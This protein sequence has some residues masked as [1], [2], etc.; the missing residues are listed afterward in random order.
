MAPPEL[1]LVAD[2]RVS[3]AGRSSCTVPDAGTG[4]QA[5]VSLS[6]PSSPGRKA[7]RPGDRCT[8][9]G[10]FPAGAGPLPCSQYLV[11]I[12]WAGSGGEPLAAEPASA[13]AAVITWSGRTLSVTVP[14]SGTPTV[15]MPSAPPAGWTSP[16]S[17]RLVTAAPDAP[18]N[19]CRAAVVW[20]PR[21]ARSRSRM[22]TPSCGS[23]CASGASGLPC[24]LNAIRS[25]PAGVTLARLLA[26]GS[27]P[28]CR[29][30]TQDSSLWLYS[31]PATGKPAV[32]QS[33][34]PDASAYSK[35]WLQCC[36]AKLL[37]SGT[38]RL[39]PSIQVP[40][41]HA[42]HARISEMQASP[43]GVTRLPGTP[44]FSSAI[45]WSARLG[46]SVQL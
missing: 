5:T 45:V 30:V 6:R 36:Q 26:E 42:L 33:P 46:S 10:R 41:G 16:S 35:V 14:R 2:I 18:V 21:P 15:T 12:G 25:T 11:K 37:P 34:E 7:S 28:S 31:W 23:G 1:R 20:L 4:P 40:L 32:R 17:S 43:Q 3:A 9:T 27:G 13:P 19:R 24:G 29:S 8:A 38:V 44:R 22:V 39:S